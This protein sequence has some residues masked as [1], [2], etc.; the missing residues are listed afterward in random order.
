[1]ARKPK[2][3]GKQVHQARGWH[4]PRLTGD[5]TQVYG[6]ALRDKARKPGSRVIARGERRNKYGQTYQ[7]YDRARTLAAPISIAMAE[8][9]YQADFEQWAADATAYFAAHGF[10]GEDPIISTGCV[11]VELGRI[12]QPWNDSQHWASDHRKA[13]SDL[14]KKLKSYKKLAAIPDAGSKRKTGI[15][16]WFL[17]ANT[18]P[19][20]PTPEPT[21]RKRSKKPTKKGTK[22][23]KARTHKARSQSRAA[24]PSM[25]CRSNARVRR[26]TNQHK[27]ARGG[28]VRRAKRTRGRKKP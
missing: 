27:L 14:S 24:V 2:V 3:H 7:V 25:G 10:P 18:R 11:T 1:M 19:T 22:H 28:T 23:A 16:G 6:G 13:A 21:K 4:A 26:R 8:P 20:D 9:L 17:R 5:A 15:L 12:F